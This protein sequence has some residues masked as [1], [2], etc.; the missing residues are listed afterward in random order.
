MRI[1]RKTIVL[2]LAALGAYKAWEFLGPKVAQARGSA[3]TVRDRVEPALED[4]KDRLGSA[5]RGAVDS[6]VDVTKDV[7]KDVTKDTADA[8]TGALNDTFDTPTR[9]STPSATERAAR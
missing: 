6:V 7:A 9:T 5:S 2:A 8:V 4:A 3:A 1:L